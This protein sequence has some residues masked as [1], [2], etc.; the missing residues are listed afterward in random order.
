VKHGKPLLVSALPS[1]V[2]IV[3]QFECGLAVQN[4]ADS[5]E[6]GAALEKIASRYD[7]YSRNALR[8]FN[9]RY[10][11]GKGAEPVIRFMD[12]L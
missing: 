1:L 3:E 5:N 6:V 7:E 2:E 11:F 9:E 10:E 12:R 8:C 4:P